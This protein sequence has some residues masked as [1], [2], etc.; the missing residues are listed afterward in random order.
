[1]GMLSHY[2]KLKGETEKNPKLDFD[3]DD[4]TKIMSVT[5]EIPIELFHFVQKLTIKGSLMDWI[6]RYILIF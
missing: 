6:K 1:V 4:I 5:G 2:R 3:E